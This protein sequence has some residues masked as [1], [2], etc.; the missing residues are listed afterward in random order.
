MR[1]QL[2][3]FISTSRWIAILA[4]LS[5]FVA[6]AE[7]ETQTRFAHSF[8]PQL[9]LVLNG[10]FTWSS[11][12]PDDYYLPGFQR[13]NEATIAAPGFAINEAELNIQSSIDPYF[14]GNM[15]LAMHQHSGA[16]EIDLEEAYIRTQM[17]PYGFA[18]TAGRFYSGFGYLN[19][20]HRHQW[21]FVD[22]PLIYRA[23]Y[24]NQ[25]Y[26]DG[27]QARWLAPTPVYWEL[28]FEAFPGQHFPAAGGGNHLGSLSLYT[29]IGD[30]FGQHSSWLWG[31]SYLHATPSEREA[32][33][34]GGHDH[35]HDHD[36]DHVHGHEH[37]DFVF[38]GRSDT[39]GMDMIWKW[40]PDGNACARQLTLQGEI[41]HRHENGEVALN[42]DEASLLKSNQN[43]FYAQAVYKFMPRWR[44]GLRYDRLW[45]SNQGNDDEV[46]T[47]T[48][49]LPNGYHPHQ[50][51]AMIDFSPSEFSRIRFQHNL[52]H[53]LPT[54]NKQYMLQFI[55]N[56][57][58]HGAH[59]F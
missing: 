38:S 49:L 18:V 55:V 53:S 9:S 54:L 39:I 35:G 47:E 6:T 23:F 57:G 16:T 8:N 11:F 12:D 22:A 17:L 7:E 2:I 26:D 1:G 10:G 48:L 56:L 30:D 25:Y 43:G 34:Q 20:H 50:T 44:V 31:I 4:L 29:H 32:L 21:D 27:V 3:K 5:P 59:D 58:A 24:N 33:L 46:L 15:T 28:G 51:T 14:Y 19:H 37:G 45:S 13:G 40:A 41:Y 42:E 52:D 36:H